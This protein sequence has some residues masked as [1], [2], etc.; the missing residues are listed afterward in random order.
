MGRSAI[1]S[2]EL[3]DTLTISEYYAIGEHSRGFWLYDK[4]RGMNLAIGAKT[5]EAALVKAITYYQKRLNSVEINY[6]SLC[7]KVDSFIGQF[8]EDE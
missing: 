6:K 4:T 7:E 1:S 2:E 8:K 5:R 3:S